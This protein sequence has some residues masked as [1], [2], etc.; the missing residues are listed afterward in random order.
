MK[1]R[2]VGKETGVEEFVLFLCPRAQREA[3]PYVSARA[4]LL[5]IQVRDGLRFVQHN[6]RD[7]PGNMAHIVAAQ[8]PV[9]PAKILRP[10]LL[11]G[12]QQASCLNPS[13]RHDHY[14]RSDSAYAWG[15]MHDQP[16]H[17]SSRRCQVEISDG[18][19]QA[20]RDA[21]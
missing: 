20:D 13:P 21:L 19:V 10:F 16:T 7:L 2:I 14:S 12:Q 18:A 11:H 9:G 6:A 1:R 8:R 4:V 5:E 15:T 3:S 17:R